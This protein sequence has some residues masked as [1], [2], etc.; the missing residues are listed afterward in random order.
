[1]VYLVL[2]RLPDAMGLAIFRTVCYAFSNV[3]EREMLGPAVTGTI[4]A[5]KAA[6][7]ANARRVVVVSSMVAV[8]INPKDWPKDKIKDENCW[9]DKEFCR[10]EENWYFVA[11]ISSEEAALE[12]AKQTRLDVVTVNPAVVFGPLLQ[13]TLNT[14]C[15]FLVYFLKGGSDRMRDKLWHI[16]DVRDTANAL[17]LVYETP[18]ASDRHICAPH[19]ISARDLLELLKT[20]YPDDYPFI[21]NNFLS[22]SDVKGHKL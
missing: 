16:V 17:L 15:Q 7:A 9:S 5:L 11:K 20:M 8:E 13:P 19:F 3:G 2:A 4:N 10:N 12:Y 14:S 1:M 22:T 21:S 6:S 18:Q